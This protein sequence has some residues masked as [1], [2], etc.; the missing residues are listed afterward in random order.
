MQQ[1]IAGGPGIGLVLYEHWGPVYASILQRSCTF[2][3][4][5]V[6]PATT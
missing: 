4:F 2:C 3:R 6:L 5:K 1:I